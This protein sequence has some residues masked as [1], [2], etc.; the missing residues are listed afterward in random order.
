MAQTFVKES[1]KP[2]LIWPASD[3]YRRIILLF[4]ALF[5]L[6]LILLLYIIIY[7]LGGTHLSYV[8]LGYLPVLLAA[9]FFA[10][11][12]GVIAGMVTGLAVGPIMPLDV[13]A[14]LSQ[15]TA[16][17]I[18]R[19]GFFVAVGTLA[20]LLVGVLKAEMRRFRESVLVDPVTRLPNRTAFV[21]DTADQ[22]GSCLIAHIQDYND[23]IVTFGPEISDEAQKV[24]AERLFSVLPSELALY[25][26]RSFRFGIWLPG[27]SRKQAEKIGETMLQVMERP[28]EVLGLSLA[29]NTVY[30]LA[31][32][33]N[34]GK[35]LP[36]QAAT[37]AV[38]MA[39]RGK[40]RSA[41]F[42]EKEIDQ[43]REALALLGDL[44]EE[45]S[46]AGG[47]LSL[48]FQPKFD[49]TTEVSR[50]A[51]ALLRW[52]H[53]ERGQLPP[54]LFMPLVEK[55]T[56]MSNLTRWVVNE[57]LKCASDPSLPEDYVVSVNVS[58]SDLEDPGFPEFI[59]SALDENCMQGA[60][61]ELEVTETAFVED[62]DILFSALKELR[63]MGITIAVDDFGTGHASLE[64]LR[65]LPVDVLKIDR[66]F[67][68]GLPASVDTE[69]VKSTVLLARA[70][71]LKVVAEGV[72]DLEIG[73]QLGQWGCH[74]AQG[75]AYARPMPF[76]RLKDSIAYSAYSG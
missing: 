35:F 37:A 8:H 53:R 24:L 10:V 50:G 41:V 52:S 71:G 44:K 57:A 14:E 22:Y 28:V 42:E 54:G 60:R 29:L 74:Y 13:G 43:R 38:E 51:E 15:P 65:H 20:G 5:I 72:E 17:W 7:Q 70:M 30:G 64:H 73:A 49:L 39:L 34:D 4:I 58:V 47:G 48:H 25:H 33:T 31:E 26:L 75:F 59:R 27:A 62:F 63:D 9:A 68:A 46:G 56:L 3:K 2:H 6:L 55:T 67:I 69:I 18:T 16:S 61:L 1:L 21:R 36:Y 32:T 23:I 11:P 66:T 12:G 40:R 19:T 45:L 76:E